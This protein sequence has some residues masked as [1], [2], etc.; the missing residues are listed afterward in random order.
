[1]ST[2]V[3]G[4]APEEHDLTRASSHTV[5][6]DHVH[7]EAQVRGT[8]LS[9]NGE[10][11]LKDH[12]LEK[13]PRRQGGSLLDRWIARTEF[14]NF[15]MF[16]ANMGTGAVEILV[17]GCAFDFHGKR[18]IGTIWFMFDFVLFFINIAGTVTRAWCHPKAFK[19]ALYSHEYGLFLPCINLAF[20]TI[21]VGVVDYGL[22]YC[23]EWLTRAWEVV[24]FIY[25]A[26][27][28]AVF[29]F[30]E[31]SVRGQLRSISTMTPADALPLFPLM[32]AGTLGSAL[33]GADK[34]PAHEAAYIIILS[35]CCQGMG[36][37]LALLR[38]SI[39]TQR[40]LTFPNPP[41]N[42]FPG[43][44][45]AVGPMGFT[46]FAFINLGFTAQT[47][48]PAA[49]IMGGAEAGRVFFYVSVWFAL[50]LWVF[51]KV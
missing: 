23:G 33:A 43:Y 32:L 28:L 29:M 8:V 17:G 6:G 18:A 19:K 40:H 41:T 12:A 26:A 3:A 9:S 13:G 31:T 30:M 20:A 39:W 14:W 37:W 35:Y 16:T 5:N 44:L 51:D 15:N 22:P 45:M 49:N 25:I 38:L 4:A 36:F 7:A 11:I 48:F 27:A 50:T 10:Q 42:T 34:M 2:D 47:A 46:A 21:F 1:M 24:W